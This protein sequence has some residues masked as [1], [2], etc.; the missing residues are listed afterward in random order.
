MSR[1]AAFDRMP[2]SPALGTAGR[3][4]E[5]EADAG[6]ASARRITILANPVAGGFRARTLG[7]LVEAIAAHGAAVS[8]HLT[9]RAGEITDLCAAG[10]PD[11]DVLAIAGGDGS[12]N[13]AIAGFEAVENP[14]ALAII[15]FGTANVL[16]HELG[17]PKRVKA[18]ADVIATGR[19]EPLHYGLS[20]GRPFVLMASSGFDASVVHALTFDL[21]RRFGKLAY[22]AGV[23]RRMSEPR[24][25]DLEVEIDGDRL[26]CRLAVVT[27]ASRYGGPFVVCP[28]ANV[29]EPT[30]HLMA[31]RHDDPFAIIRLG[32]T[33]LF[34]RIERS[35]DVVVREV[36]EVVRLDA[37]R[38]V[39]CQLDGDTFGSTP[40]EITPGRR[41]LRI[42]V[43]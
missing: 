13:E 1:S 40:L 35:R 28:A 18:L 33:L 27:N 14:P 19:T 10:M 36:R 12:I 11:T 21:K 17:L 22:V 2:S 20:N 4:G 26:S 37:A 9:R 15:P 43:P 30:L 31:V 24:T 5:A 39:P 42:V 7:R 8:L 23:F 38:P 25:A 6:H 34:G 41:A 32:A 29:H 16:A 3:T